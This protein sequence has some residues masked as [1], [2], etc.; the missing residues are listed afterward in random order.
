[1]YRRISLNC[2]Q[3]KAERGKEG[4]MRE[5]RQEGLIPGV[6]GWPNLLSV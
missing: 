6:P 3:D 4:K 2:K 1:M 5:V